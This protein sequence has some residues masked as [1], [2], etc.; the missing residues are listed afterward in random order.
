MFVLGYGRFHDGHIM[1]SPN[2]NRN[3]EENMI[4]KTTELSGHLHGKNIKVEVLESF[5]ANSVDVRATNL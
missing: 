4:A 2:L 3:I 5:T 1:M